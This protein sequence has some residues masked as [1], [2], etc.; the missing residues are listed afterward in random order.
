[1][2]EVAKAGG[3]PGRRQG[4]LL[5]GLVSPHHAGH[6]RPRLPGG[7]AGQAQ[8]LP[9]LNRERRAV[10]ADGRSQCV[11]DPPSHQPFVACGWTGSRAY[12]RL[13]C[14]APHAPGHR[15]TMPLES[16]QSLSRLKTKSS[17]VVFSETA[18]KLFHINALPEAGWVEQLRLKWRS[19]R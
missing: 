10:P 11:R 5:A 7:H 17:T 15:Q 4:A 3:R 13:V 18:K 6:A 8:C 2:L 9:T 16:T 1:M 19:S 14:L 12:L